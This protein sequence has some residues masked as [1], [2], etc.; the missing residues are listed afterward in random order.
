MATTTSTDN[1]GL[2]DVLLPAFKKNAGIDVHVIA[3]GTGKALKYGENGDVDVVFVHARKA[4]D[5]FVANGFGVGRK[6][7]MYND[8][9]ILGPA[10]DPAG[11]KGCK[12]ATEAL[13]KIAGSKSAFVSRGDESGTHKKEKSLW[14]DANISPA[15]KWYILAGQG[16]GAVLTMANEKQAYTMADRGTSIAFEDKIDLVTLCEG[17]PKLFNPYGIIAVN[18]E[19]H[20]HVKYKEAT[21]F[22]EW[23]TSEQGQKIIGAFKKK[24]KQLFHPNATLA[25]SA[26]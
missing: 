13:A 9:V 10:K 19:K 17:D 21:E 2:L 24:G 20:K 5:T 15:G 26:R 1:S 7:V 8:F 11:I 4:E 3:V 16:M 23:I 14:E 18:P 12:K 22:I 25:A 6:D